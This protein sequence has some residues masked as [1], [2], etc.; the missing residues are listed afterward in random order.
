MYLKS[1][2]IF[3]LFTSFGRSSESQ[4]LFSKSFRPESLEVELLNNPNDLP[5]L[6][7]FGPKG[8]KLISTTVEYLNISDVKLFKLNGQTVLAVTWPMGAHSHQLD[9]YDLKKKKR[10][11]FFQS[12][13]EISIL[14]PEKKHELVISS[15]ENGKKLSKT[16]KPF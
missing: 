12:D 16:F 13:Y 5:R 2:L 3:F 1:F 7:V 10:I 4:I 9:L 6:V 15:I 8:R 11:V 14:K